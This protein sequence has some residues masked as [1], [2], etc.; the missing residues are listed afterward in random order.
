MADFFRIQL[1][2]VSRS[3]GHS[4]AKRSAYQSCSIVVAHDGE[5]FD[6]RRKRREHVRT[7]ML[8]PDGAPGWTRDPETLWHRA[9][10]AEKRIDAQ[11]ARIVDFSMPRAIP[12]E[13]WG[14]CIAHVY[15]PYVSMGM[16]LQIDIHDTNASDGGRN[17]NVHGLATLRPLDGDGFS[18]KKNRAWNDLFRERS[19]RGVREAFAERL[20]GFCRAHGIDYEG[21]ARPNA[22]RDHPAPEPE[23]PKWNFEA[24]R[25]GNEMPEALAALL[26]HRRHRRAWE[27]ARAEEIEA[28]LDLRK[29]EAEIRKRRQRRTVPADPTQRRLDERD[30]RAAILR[31]WH[32]IGW[33][34]AE[35]VVGIASTRFD[36]ERHCLWIDLRDGSTLVD[37][38]DFIALRGKL[39]WTAALETVAAAERHGWVEIDVHGDQEYRDMVTMAA[40]LRG[41]PVTNHVLS[42][43]AQH[44]FEQLKAAQDARFTAAESGT[45]RHEESRNSPRR[46]ESRFRSGSSHEIH[47]RLRKR[48]IVPMAMEHPDHEDGSSQLPALG[49]PFQKKGR[50]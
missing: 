42:P 11:E 36:A 43:V 44:R 39:T 1:G 23:L 6:F 41:I 47:Q 46:H 19:G 25:R 17:V 40:L 49:P 12:A 27:N 18:S 29:L 14:A 33:I 26:E 48:A 15:E 20:T 37:R 34:D 50:P 31:V 38:G 22:E 21:D 32:G 9:A 16:V 8:A 10:E 13:L 45:E 24:A 3:E 7:V 30:R 2:I 5:R 35:A 28:A 4:G